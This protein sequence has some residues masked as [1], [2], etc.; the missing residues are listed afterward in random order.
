MCRIFAHFGSVHH[1]LRSKERL[2]RPN[3]PYNTPRPENQRKQKINDEI[4]A[5]EL[6][7]VDASGGQLGILTRREALRIAQERELDLVEIAP[8]AKPPVAKI[9]D[10]GK[11]VYEQ[12]KRE[13]EQK[14]AQVHSLLKEIRFRAGTDT[15]DVDFKTR[16]AREFLE[17]GHKVK[18]TVLFRGREI[19]HQE[20]GH[21]LLNRFIEA[22]A[23]ISKID[24]GVKMEGRM[25]S[26]TI[27]P[28]AKKVAAKKKAEKK[29][30]AQSKPKV[31]KD[32]KDAQTKPAEDAADDIA[33]DIS[34]VDTLEVETDL[35]EAGNSTVELGDSPA[36]SES[37]DATSEST[38]S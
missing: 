18:A 21:A 32:G 16:H 1:P 17:E 4:T 15:H 20:F 37:D 23:D 30:E 7:V 9:I 26:V 8:Q 12:Q 2:R 22:L 29:Q 3:N 33:D 34:D 13:K 38:A 5:N 14:K 28:D 31:G 19:V 35:V 36:A 10:Y 27:A 11:F 25:L 6:R 24:Q